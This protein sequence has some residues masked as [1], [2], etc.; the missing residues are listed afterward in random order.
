MKRWLKISLIGIALVL[1]VV[2]G[3]LAWFLCNALPV[4]TGFVAK[5]LCSSTFISQRNP[6]I[7]FQEDVAPINPISKAVDWQ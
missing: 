6:E 5:Y 3:A 1:I 7:V 2:L 4:G